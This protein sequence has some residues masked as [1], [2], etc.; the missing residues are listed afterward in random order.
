MLSIHAARCLFLFLAAL[1][2][3]GCAVMGTPQ[4]ELPEVHPQGVCQVEIKAAGRR[5]SRR[6]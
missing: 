2:M 6:W 4:A 5:P 3:S 1:G